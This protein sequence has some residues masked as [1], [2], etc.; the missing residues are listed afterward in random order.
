M[1]AKIVRFLHS[2]ND[3]MDRL[4]GIHFSSFPLKDRMHK[5]NDSA[6][7][8]A[9]KVFPNI[10]KFSSNFEMQLKPTEHLESFYR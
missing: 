5:T 1:S 4:P 9:K 8:A 3:K 10:R 6:T 2:D 7:V